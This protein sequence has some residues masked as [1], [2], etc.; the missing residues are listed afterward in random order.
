MIFVDACFYVSV[1][2]VTGLYV[3]PG[4]ISSALCV[5][6]SRVI[7][8]PS[9]TQWG[10]LVSPLAA[11]DTD[12]ERLTGSRAISPQARRLGVVTVVNCPA[13]CISVGKPPAHPQGDPHTEPSPPPSCPADSISSYEAQI[14]SLKQERQQQQQDCEEREQE[15][16]RLKQLLARAHPLDSLEKQMEKV[17]F[18]R[19]SP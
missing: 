17:G 7:F 11:E 5:T 10:S 12:A 3:G 8:D 19:A 14:A 13:Q 9:A 4:V 1:Y 18:G 16:G 15:L 6:P 2:A